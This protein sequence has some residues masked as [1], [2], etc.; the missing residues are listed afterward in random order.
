MNKEV[1]KRINKK[2]L[3]KLERKIRV[4]WLGF[5]QSDLLDMSNLSNK[6]GNKNMKYILVIIDIYSRKIWC[7]PLKHKYSKNVAEKIE[8]WINDIKREKGDIFVSFQN[9][10]GGEFKGETRDLLK[11]EGIRQYTADTADHHTQSIVER[12]NQTLRYNFRDAFVENNNLIWYGTVL[13]EIVDRY[14]NRVHSGIKAVPNKVWNEEEDPFVVP[15]NKKAEDLE[16]G[17]RVRILLKKHLFD[18]KSQTSSYS[19]RVYRV[20]ERDGGKYLLEGKTGR[21]ARWQLLKTKAPIT[22]IVKESLT[23][24]M[25]DVKGKNMVKRVLKRE[26]IDKKNIVTKK[27]L[28]V[29]RLKTGTKN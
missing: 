29:K 14:N 8:S 27:R 17:D 25:R 1:N 4:P 19:E 21:Y 24:K 3:Q 11:R 15:Q 28:R 12:A 20:L 13:D 16:K 23:E 5:F 26:G 9:D 2:I 22:Q 18:K 7:Y 6:R 10:D